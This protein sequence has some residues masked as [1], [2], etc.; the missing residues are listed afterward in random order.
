MVLNGRKSYERTQAWTDNRRHCTT[1]L[2][3]FCCALNSKA[4]CLMLLRAALDHL[5]WNLSHARQ[6]KLL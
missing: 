5:C 4:A 2:Q 3:P 6:V 1:F